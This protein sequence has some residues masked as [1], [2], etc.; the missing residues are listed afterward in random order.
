MKNGIYCFVCL[1]LTLPSQVLGTEPK[2]LTEL[3]PPY[4]YEEQGQLKGLAAEVVIETINHAKFESKIELYPFARTM[5][6]AKQNSPIIAFPVLKT[7][8]R[9]HLF[10]WIGPVAKDQFHFYRLA[11]RTNLRIE[12]LEDVKFLSVAT[13]RGGA[14][15]TLLTELDFPNIHSVTDIEQGM[16]MLSLGHVDVI[17][18]ARLTFEYYLNILQRKRED[19]HPALHIEALDREAYLAASKSVPIDTVSKL[20]ASLEHIHRTGAYQKIEERF[21]QQSKIQNSGQ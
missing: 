2:F 6:L 5:I 4:V 8:S 18:M 12:Q 21:W 7:D 9:E 17:A 19:F 3:Y 15:E 11:T 13:V 20:K 10:Q 14:V 16:N 1:I